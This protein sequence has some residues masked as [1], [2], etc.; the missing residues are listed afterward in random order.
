MFWRGNLQST[1]C[2]IT[3]LQIFK[4]KAKSSPQVETS[5]SHLPCCDDALYDA[6][7][8]IQASAGVLLQSQI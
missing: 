2:Y 6:L 5:F 7:V 1:I 8:Y 3:F 4:Q